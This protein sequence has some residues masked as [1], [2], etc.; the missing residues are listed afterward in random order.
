M[1]HQGRI[2]IFKWTAVVL[3][4]VLLS[5]V[6]AHWKAFLGATGVHTYLALILTLTLLLALLM[7]LAVAVYAEEKS[8]GN[9]QSPKAVL[10]Y[11]ANRF[12]MIHTTRS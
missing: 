9:V 10:D 2:K 7:A 6:I 11:W 5:R 12:F 4:V 3:N 8:K 1:Y